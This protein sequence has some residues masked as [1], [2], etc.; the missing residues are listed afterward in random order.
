MMKPRLV[1]GLVFVAIILVMSGSTPTTSA[2]TA[3]S[4]E[5][6]PVEALQRLLE[7]NSRYVSG[8]PEHPNSRPS[9]APQHPSAVILSCS[10]SRVPPEIIFDQGIGD[11][12]VVRVAGNT[13]D[14]MLLETI[15]YGVEHL[16]ARLILVIGHDQCGAVTA[17]VKA[18]PDPHVGEMLKNIYPAVK[19]AKDA[20]GDRVSAAISINAVLV[21]ARLAAEPQL[22][23]LVAQGKLKILPARYEMATGRVKILGGE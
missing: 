7:G 6:A 17:A 22:S 13:Y 16:G 4:Q 15:D 3:Q 10:D 20:Q 9:A 5:I 8:H 2:A 12:F 14:K 11:V 23:H 1:I 19:D 18:Y 21:A